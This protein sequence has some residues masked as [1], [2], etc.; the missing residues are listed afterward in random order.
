MF[1]NNWHPVSQMKDYP[2]FPNIII[3]K[4][5]GIYLIDKHEKKYIDIISSWWCKSLGHNHPKLKKSIKKQINKFEHVIF[6]NTTHDHIIQLG[7]ILADKFQKLKKVFYAGD[8]STAVEIALK[9][10]IQRHQQIGFP[11]KTKFA[12]LQN[13]YHG[14]TIMCFSVSDLG[15]YKDKFNSILAQ[16]I[17]LP[18]TYSK[19]EDKI[20][21]CLSKIE[22]IIEKNAAVISGVI[23]EPL[24]Q[25]AAGMKIY[26]PKIIDRI[27]E[28]C[29]KHHIH[30]IYD[31]IMTGFWK[32]G[33]EFAL[34]HSKYEPD[35][36]CLM[37]G[38][39]AGWTP[40]SVVMTSEQIYRNFYGNYETGNAFMHSNTFSGYPLGVAVSLEVLKQYEKMNIKKKIKEINQWQQSAFEEINNQLDCFSQMRS[41][42][43]II[44]G[45]LKNPKDHPRLGYA[46]YQ[47]AI[48]RGLLLRPLGNTLY[49]LPPYVITKKQMSKARDIALKA[50]KEVIK[51]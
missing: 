31:E 8:G 40:F 36:L 43:A 37:K 39:S 13:A 32:T 28:I 49:F 11:Q 51:K 3:K 48:K 14:E 24:V 1:E 44:A 15:L 23:I 47:E 10:S 21:D 25:G 41:L 27:F 30:L 5:R 2:S 42:G 46:I 17:Q 29:Q 35:F 22:S 38:L 20:E 7:K 19:E 18:I 16:N 6:A 4:A 12:F 9:M 33:E 34:N 45:D 50:I 26:S